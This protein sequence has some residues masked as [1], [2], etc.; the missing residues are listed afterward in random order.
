L[1]PNYSKSKTVK[2]ASCLDL[3]QSEHVGRTKGHAISQSVEDSLA[4]SP[5]LENQVYFEKIIF[6]T[7]LKSGY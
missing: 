5:C 7:I 3:Q 4:S 6:V 2:T 1:K